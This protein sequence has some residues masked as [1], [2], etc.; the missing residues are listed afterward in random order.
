MV[1][2]V[3]LLFRQSCSSLLAA[4]SLTLILWGT[5]RHS[6]M[7]KARLACYTTPRTS[8][9]PVDWHRHPVPLLHVVTV[10]GHVYRI[11]RV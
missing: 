5:P 1:Q 10:L 7:T 3:C 9:M 11:P 8:R 2:A 4:P 6:Y